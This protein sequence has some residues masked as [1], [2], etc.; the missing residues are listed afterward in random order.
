[1]QR[2]PLVIPASATHTATVIFFHGLGDSG[3][4]WSPV[5]EEIRKPHVK[6]ILPHASVSVCACVVMSDMV[7]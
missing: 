3:D 6:Y 2:A 5:F 4:G 7:S 1:M